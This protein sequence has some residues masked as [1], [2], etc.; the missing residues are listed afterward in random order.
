MVK[1]YWEHAS[2]SQS[3]SHISVWTSFQQSSLNTEGC[4]VR[5]L[6]SKS[7]FFQFTAI[8]SSPAVG[9]WLHLQ[10]PC[11]EITLP[12][13]WSTDG[14]QPFST[15]TRTHPSIGL[16][17]SPAFWTWDAHPGQVHLIQNRLLQSWMNK[18]DEQ[19][20]L[21]FLLHILSPFTLPFPF[22]PTPSPLVMLALISSLKPD[23]LT[24]MHTVR[25]H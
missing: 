8:I 25:N 12:D 5:L 9:F 23:K 2:L 11:P 17:V 3:I 1:N 22:P 24:K 4:K 21:I 14:E 7:F 6:C 20:R 15:P 13:K 10:P 18:W 19:V 16:W